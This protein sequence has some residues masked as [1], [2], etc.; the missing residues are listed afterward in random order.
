[1]TTS[2]TAE[3]LTTELRV[4]GLSFL[5][6]RDASP[7]YRRLSS[8]ELMAS[9]AAQRDARLRSSL[10]ALLLSNSALAKAIPSALDQLD[11]SAQLTLKIYYMAAV[12]LQAKYAEQLRLLVPDW[13]PLP[14]LFSKELG[15]FYTDE[16]EQ[17]LQQLG[18][19]HHQ[20]TGL[21]ANW[22]GTYEY[23]AARLI[24][25]LEKEAAW[26]A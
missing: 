11:A 18:Q 16:V 9:L 3:E 2:L 20:L 8:S 25:R 7:T 23:A 12:I 21:A 14:D 17:R 10:I 24:R 22:S 1:M 4:H 6:G 15:L 19:M 13:Q 5:V 26:I